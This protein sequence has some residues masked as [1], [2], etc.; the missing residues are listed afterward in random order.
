MSARRADQ[1]SEAFA[2]PVHTA[3][4]VPGKTAL[5]QRM[6]RG[7][8]APSSA[9]T[10]ARPSV[11]RAA[12]A[13]ELSAAFGFAD[14]PHDATDAAA[15]ADSGPRAVGQVGD[16]HE[17]HADTVAAAVVRGESVAALLGPSGASSAVPT[18]QRFASDEHQTLG[19]QATGGRMVSLAPDY[20]LSYGDMV[21]IAGDYFESI[22]Q[23]RS[24]AAVPGPGA[25]TREEIDYVIERYVR[26]GDGKGCSADAREA[27]DARYYRLLGQNDAHYLNN[28]R[29]EQADTAERRAGR[30]AGATASPVTGADDLFASIRLDKLAANAAGAYRRGHV[31]A[32]RE[33]FVAGRNSTDPTAA[34][35]SN[36]RTV[37]DAHAADAYACHFLTD[38]FSAGHIR[39]QRTSIAAYW[40]PKEPMFVHNTKGWIAETLAREVAKHSSKSTDLAFHGVP[41]LGAFGAFDQVSEKMTALQYRFGDL[42]GVALHELDGNGGVEVE[43]AGRRARIYGDHHLGDGDEQAWAQE[44]VAASVADVEL[45]FRLGAGGSL[46]VVAEDQL[47]LD[48]LFAAEKLIPTPVADRDLPAADDRVRWWDYSDALTLI[49]APKVIEA[50]RAFGRNQAAEIEAV[51]GTFDASVQTAIK[52][53]VV[54]ALKA[55]PEQAVHDI[56]VWTP[57]TG[58][59]QG[60]HNQDDNASDYVAAARGTAAIG[61]GKAGLASLRFHQRV[62]LIE[63]LLDGAT[64]GQQETDV[65][66]LLT[67]AP[68]WEQQSLITAIGWK[69]LHDE[70]DDGLGEAFAAAFPEDPY[71]R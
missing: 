59:G 50:L 51:A 34:Y 53:S 10:P 21:A 16:A 31:R 63:Q 40:N 12:L 39:T 22:D 4:R 25:G 43:S 13:H 15:A 61:K 46:P 23:L 20:Q 18:V 38:S 36:L 55:T 44:A 62:T 66:D 45:A 17:H 5:T 26:G 71:G 14:H 37:D 11:Q 58:G 47:M 68:T 67:S 29:E 54:A 48:G 8:A 52:A 19:D 42:I 9:V 7:S 33:A 24:L 6:V 70:L 1:V 56:L 69:R 65:L 28:Q 35:Q 41:M 64:A 27:A 2:A 3:P 49:K 32:L 30:T 60:G 57:N